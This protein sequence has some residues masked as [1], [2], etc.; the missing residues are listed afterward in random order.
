MHRSYADF[1][2]RVLIIGRPNP[3][4]RPFVS[5]RPTPLAAFEAAAKRG[6]LGT[7]EYAYRTTSAPDLLRAIRWASAIVLDDVTSAEIVAPVSARTRNVLYTLRTD[8]CHE[9]RRGALASEALQVMGLASSVIAWTK[10]LRDRYQPFAHRVDLLGL[11]DVAQSETSA[12]WLQLENRLRGAE[13]TSMFASKSAAASVSIGEPTA[14]DDDAADRLARARI[15]LRDGDESRAELLYRACIEAQPLW[16]LPLVGLAQ[17]EMRRGRWAEVS[18]LAKHALTIAPH[19][20]SALACE[21]RAVEQLEGPDAAEHRALRALADYPHSSEL[22]RQV[23]RL[24]L[25]RDNG[26]GAEEA[27]RLALFAHPHD[28]L[29]QRELGLRLYQRRRMSEAGP[30]LDAVAA[31]APEDAD[32]QYVRACCAL[33]N[34]NPDACRQALQAALVAAPNHRR[35]QNLLSSLSGA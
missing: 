3:V 10:E 14:S 5:P 33:Q 23:A 25:A 31:F 7:G 2:T 13:A 29:S 15:A 16:H 17:L 22:Y 20:P 26:P 34:G 21:V 18:S 9:S 11:P 8:V 35:S 27:Y 32:V 6:E 30:L 4:D 24:R 12:L 1:A 28:L 19:S